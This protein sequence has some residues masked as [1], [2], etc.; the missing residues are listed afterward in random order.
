MKNFYYFVKEAKTLI[1]LSLLSNVF[2]ILSTSLIFFL[3]AMVISGWKISNKAVEAIQGEAEISIYFKEGIDK[4]NVIQLLENIKALDEVTEASLIDENQAYSRMSEILGDD[5]Q[6]LTYVDENPFSPF[7]EVKINLEKIDS[8]LEKLSVIQNVEHVRDNRE[9]LDR[10]QNLSTMLKLIGYLVVIAV[11][12]CTVVIISHI[13]RLGIYNN[14]EQIET[15]RLLGAPERFIALPFLLEGLV[16][17]VGGGIL[18]LLITVFS[19]KSVYSGIS[20]PLPFIP[21]PP[22]EPLLSS[23]MVYIVI[24][25]AS[26]G[27]IGSI[28][29]MSTA[30]VKG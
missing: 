9:V 29:G 20:A 23:V 25:S 8:A 15:L 14:R 24:M 27:I 2:S 26:L 19:L 1:K 5:T 11:S 17:T 30:K 7:I 22:L 3:L 21:L 28:I 16:I 18:S 13:I 10:L 12:V 6:V 4:S